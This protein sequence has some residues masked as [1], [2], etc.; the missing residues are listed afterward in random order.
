MTATNCLGTGTSNPRRVNLSPIPA[1]AEFKQLGMIE[2]TQTV[3]GPDNPTPLIAS[4]GTNSKRTFARVYLGLQGGAS[5]IA[6][7]TG[8]LTAVRPDGSRPGGRS[9]STP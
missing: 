1:G 8:R 6:N 9:A 7:V 2:I 4:S 3:Q 5:S